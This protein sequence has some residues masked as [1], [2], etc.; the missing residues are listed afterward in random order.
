MFEANPVHG[1]FQGRMARR[2][3]FV[4][5]T[6]QEKN[7]ALPRPTTIGQKQGTR[8]SELRNKL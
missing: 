5:H 1:P 6:V 3:C 8:S 4:K 2:R 7:A